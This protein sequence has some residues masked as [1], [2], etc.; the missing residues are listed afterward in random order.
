MHE[1]VRWWPR[2]LF[3]VVVGTAT[4][5]NELH[6]NSQQGFETVQNPAPYAAK[7]QKPTKP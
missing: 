6:C 1:Y 4:R 7:V 5:D 2:K 3:H